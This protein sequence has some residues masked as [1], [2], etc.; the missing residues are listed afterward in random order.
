MFSGEMGGGEMM[1]GFRLE[2][3]LLKVIA[4]IEEKD[5]RHLKIRT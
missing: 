4:R 2:A 5:K 1:R 3:G